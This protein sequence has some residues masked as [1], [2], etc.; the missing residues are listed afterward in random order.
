MSNLVIV[1]IVVVY[2]SCLFGTINHKLCKIYNSNL[3]LDYIVFNIY[4]V[5]FL[6]FS[7]TLVYDL[8]V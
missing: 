8:I 6:P 4:V 7:Q 5:H 3:Y 1:Q 2:K